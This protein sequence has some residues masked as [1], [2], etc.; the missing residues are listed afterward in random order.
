MALLTVTLYG[1]K[2]QHQSAETEGVTASRRSA[3]GI[4]KFSSMRGHQVNA[5]VCLSAF[6]P[7]CIKRCVQYIRLV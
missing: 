5:P 7:F 4:S 2:V 6:S 3:D 1:L